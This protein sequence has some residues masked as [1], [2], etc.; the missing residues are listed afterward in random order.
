MAQLNSND[1]VQLCHE[2]YLHR[3][4]RSSLKYGVSWAQVRSYSRASWRLCSVGLYQYMTVLCSA[5]SRYEAPKIPFMMVL[6]SHKFDIVISTIRRFSWTNRDS[7]TFHL[8]QFHLSVPLSSERSLQ[9]IT[10]FNSA[11]RSTDATIAG[12]WAR[13]IRLKLLRNMI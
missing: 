1:S 5:Q 3:S 8:P 2:D 6:L 12:A 13:K 11:F 4:V 9:C 7:L 10:Y